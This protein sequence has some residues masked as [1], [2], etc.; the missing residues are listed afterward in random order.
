MAIGVYGSAIN[1]SQ[2]DKVNVCSQPEPEP[3]THTLD[4]YKL[5]TFSMQ[6]LVLLIVKIYFDDPNALGDLYGNFHY[7]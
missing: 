6:T 4:W 7:K 2:I 1:S 3:L 5:L